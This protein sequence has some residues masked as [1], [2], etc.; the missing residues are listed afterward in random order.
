MREHS[1]V[2]HRN[3]S[4][5][6]HNGLTYARAAQGQPGATRKETIGGS[7]R[8]IHAR[9]AKSKLKLLPKFKPPPEPKPRPERASLTRAE[10]EP[11]KVEAR[12]EEERGALA[13]RQAEFDHDRRKLEAD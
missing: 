5:A 4:A 6:R 3:P 9:N 11:A 1:S 12:H 10:Q 13:R 2:P 7:W 8:S